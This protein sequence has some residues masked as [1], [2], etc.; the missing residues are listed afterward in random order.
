MI[1]NFIDGPLWYFSLTVFTIGVIWKLVPILFGKK[2]ADLS[3]ARGSG[4]PGAIKTVFSR[5]KADQGMAPQ[6]RLQIVAG[7]MFHLGVF[8]VLFVSAP[9]VLFLQEHFQN[10]S[11]NF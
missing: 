6:I 4:I 9:Q 7:Y 11:L 1:R 10:L 3:M 8:A 2:K 5:F